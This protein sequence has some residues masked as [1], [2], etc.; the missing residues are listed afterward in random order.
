MKEGIDMSIYAVHTDT[1]LSRSRFVQDLLAIANKEAENGKRVLVVTGNTL[2]ERIKEMNVDNRVQIA[3]VAIE[4]LQQPHE[5]NLPLI[6]QLID[7][8]KPDV[9]VLDTVDRVLSVRPKFQA[10]EWE[11]RIQSLQE[12]VLK[13]N[14]EMYGTILFR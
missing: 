7:E 4:S 2:H 10:E 1:I 9:I 12:F 11:K 13:K 14:V 6:E 3:V 5:L 8:Y